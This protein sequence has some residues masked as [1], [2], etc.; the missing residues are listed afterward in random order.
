MVEE[1]NL[2]RSPKVKKVP[3]LLKFYQRLVTE[4]KQ[5]WQF[6][7]VRKIRS[8]AIDSGVIVLLLL[9]LG[10]FL[11]DE[12]SPGTNWL[13]AFYATTILLLGGYA[14]LFGELQPISEVPGW[15]Q[16]FALILTIIGTVFVGILYALITENLLSSKFELVLNR[17]AIPTEGHLILVGLGKVGQRVAGILQDLKESLVAISFNQDLIKPIYPIFP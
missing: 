11:F 3:P 12:Y 4:V 13:Y 7:F 15:L 14:D 1:F 17:P 6:N 16:L 8:I 9:T 10:T 2:A 5:L